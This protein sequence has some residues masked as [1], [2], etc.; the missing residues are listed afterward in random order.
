MKTVKIAFS[1]EID[2]VQNDIGYLVGFMFGLSKLEYD[3]AAY[4]QMLK[5]FS[6]ALNTEILKLIPVDDL[7]NLHQDVNK[8]FDEN[9]QE[10]MDFVHSELDKKL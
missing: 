3:N 4:S 8:Y 2:D 6:K 1:F 9:R 7:I 10:V 5:N